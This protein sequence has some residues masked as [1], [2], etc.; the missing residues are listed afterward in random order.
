MR[1]IVLLRHGK[2]EIPEK[3]C[4]G[5]TDVPLPEEGRREIQRLRHPVLVLPLQ[6][7]GDGAVPDGVAVGLFPG[8]EPG[9][10]P[11]RGGM[12]VHRGDVL[13][14]GIIEGAEEG[15][16]VRDGPL[17]PE[18]C[19]L[20][21]G[22]DPGVGAAGALELDGFSQGRRQ[23]LFQLG[24]NGLFG[25]ALALPPVVAAAVVLHRHLVVHGISPVTAAF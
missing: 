17:R 18:G 22:V 15:P 11:L 23:V 20:A 8:G 5:I 24:L 3:T 9:V 2:P 4:L 21:Q 1:E 10:E 19:H 7:I 13:W 25:V 16:A 12:E 14:Q 6:H